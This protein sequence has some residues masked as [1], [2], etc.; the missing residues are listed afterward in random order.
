[1][2]IGVRLQDGRWTEAQVHVHRPRYRAVRTLMFTR[3]TPKEITCSPSVAGSTGPDLQLRRGNLQCEDA[4]LTRTART[5]AK[6]TGMASSSFPADA[7]LVVKETFGRAQK[8]V[9]R[10]QAQGFPGAR[11]MDEGWRSL[12]WLTRKLYCDECGETMQ[13]NAQARSQAGR[14]YYYYCAPPSGSCAR[15]RSE[16]LD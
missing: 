8:A 9:R 15:R 7:A 11:G 14:T 16:G 3:S 6:A 2:A 5:L 4:G 13:G 10:E 1:M 12:A